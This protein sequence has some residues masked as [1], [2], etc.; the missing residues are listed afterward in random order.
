M[1]EWFRGEAPAP[2][3]PGS[4]L[5]LKLC[6]FESCLRSKSG[7]FKGKEKNNYCSLMRSPRGLCGDY[8]LKAAWCGRSHHTHFTDDQS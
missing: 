3:L 1:F 8:L 2:S 6:E 7:I 5:P 4:A